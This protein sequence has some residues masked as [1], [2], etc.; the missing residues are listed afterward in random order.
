MMNTK[1]SYLYRDADNYKVHNYAI[2]SG[3]ITEAQIE[4]IIS[5]LD[6]LEY[7]IP[8]LVG[9]PEK[10]FDTYD[11]TVD[12]PFF[13]LDESRFEK[14]DLEPTVDINTEQLVQNFIN[15]KDNWTD[16]AYPF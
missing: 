4:T 1:I 15:N 11:I 10:R 16:F 3:P 12:H 5:C 14:T 2:I 9:L 7:F 6:E 13:E 8:H